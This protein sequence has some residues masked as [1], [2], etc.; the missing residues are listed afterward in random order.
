MAQYLNQFSQSPEKGQLDVTSSASPRVL[1]CYADSDLV[2]GQAVKLVNGSGKVPHVTACT[3]DTE[4]VFGFVTYSLKNGSYS[5]GMVV[6]VAII[7]S[8]MVMEASAAIARGAQLNIVVSGN[9]VVTSA[10]GVK[11]I[12]GW[13]FDKASS[14]G[15]LIRVFIST[16]SYTYSAAQ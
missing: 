3:A 5:S 10:N 4:A 14:S 11:N 7:G 6:E 16:P 2:A 13:A 1:Q 15:D 8:V 9:I 12:I